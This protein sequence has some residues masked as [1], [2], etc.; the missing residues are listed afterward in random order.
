MSNYIYYHE[1][2]KCL[3]CGKKL[4]K[5]NY[6]KHTLSRRHKEIKKLQEYKKQKKFIISFN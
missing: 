3:I 5:V 4:Y 2:M 6:E 1:K